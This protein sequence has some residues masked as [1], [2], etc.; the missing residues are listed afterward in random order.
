M[1]GFSSHKDNTVTL[2]FPQ[3]YEEYCL[4]EHVTHTLIGFGMFYMH[5]NHPNGVGFAFSF[6][7]T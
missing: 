2:F 7:A 3:P 6:I 5:F 4:S 1:N